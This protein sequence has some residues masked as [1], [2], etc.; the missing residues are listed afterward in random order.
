MA[1]IKTFDFSYLVEVKNLLKDIFY[2]EHSK[3]NFK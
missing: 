2:N 1:E 3:E